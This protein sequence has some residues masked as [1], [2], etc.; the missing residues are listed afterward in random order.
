MGFLLNSPVNPGVLT[1]AAVA[2]SSPLGLWTEQFERFY[3]FDGFF[4][5]F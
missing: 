5:H 1:Q 2:A 3:A 4:E